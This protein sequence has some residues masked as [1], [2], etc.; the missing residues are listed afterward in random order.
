MKNKVKKI[1]QTFESKNATLVVHDAQV[2]DSEN[3]KIVYDSFFK[4]RN[5]GHGVIKNIYK[6]TYIG[7]CMA[8]DS[9]IKEK[10]L[11]IPNDIEMH[12][13]WIGILNDL[14][15]NKAVFIEEKLI[16]YRR[17]SNNVSEMKRYPICKMIKNR[18]QLI[19]EIIKIIKRKER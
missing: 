15:F 13:Q 12:D 1:L 7:C 10:I 3:K 2:F 14:Y 11:P 18:M 17:H 19:K 4:Y 16:K 6:N 5:S 9:K 8:F